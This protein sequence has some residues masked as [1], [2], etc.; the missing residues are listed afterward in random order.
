MNCLLRGDT[1]STVTVKYCSI[2]F[3]LGRK[4]SS[5]FSIL[6]NNFS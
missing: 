6:G 1:T 3:V 4:F 5:G 2:V